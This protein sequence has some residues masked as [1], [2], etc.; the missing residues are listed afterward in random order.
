MGG[1][2]YLLPEEVCARL[3]NAVTPK[4]LANWRS[5]G[6]GPPFSKLGGRVFYL[7]DGLERWEDA[8]VQPAGSVEGRA[9]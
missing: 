5:L 7:A 1:A 6:M 9:S 2:K 8:R 3:H 4:T